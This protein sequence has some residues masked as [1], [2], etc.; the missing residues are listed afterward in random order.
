MQ[1]VAREM[2]N[3]GVSINVSWQR[4]PRHKGRKASKKQR[5]NEPN[6]NHRNLPVSRILLHSATFLSGYLYTLHVKC[7]Q[8]SMNS[9]SEV[10]CVASPAITMS[11]PACMPL[12]CFSVEQRTPPT[13]WM[14]RFRRS[15]VRKVRK[16]V[17]GWEGWVLISEKVAGGVEGVWGACEVPL[18]EIG[19]RRIFARDDPCRGKSRRLC[20]LGRGSG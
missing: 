18:G 12:G 3:R 2:P 11:M 7:P 1:I 20:M 9:T 17:R 15:Q 10:I 19:P 13:P 5:R 6:K 14:E 4:P 8:Q 16:R